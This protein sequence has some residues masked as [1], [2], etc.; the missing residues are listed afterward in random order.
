[1]KI[2]K[3]RK[4]TN[5]VAL[6]GMT[7]LLAILMLSCKEEIE[8]PPGCKINLIGDKDGIYS[9][10]DT[11]KVFASIVDFH[12][13]IDRMY[14]NINGKK[15]LVEKQMTDFEYQISPGDMNLGVN[16][17][18]FEAIDINGSKGSDQVQFELLSDKPIVRTDTVIIN[19]KTATVTGSLLSDGGLESSWGICF[20]EN[21]EPT[22]NDNKIKVTDKLFD[23]TIPKDKIEYGKKYFVRSWAENSNGISYG[24]AIEFIVFDYGLLIDARDNKEYK[25][26][27]IGGLTWMAENLAWEGDGTNVIHIVSYDDWGSSTNG[28]IYYLN[29]KETYEQFG[30]YYQFDAAKNACPSGWHLP[31]TDEWEILAQSA[32][33]RNLAGIALKSKDGWKDEGNG[34]DLLGFNILP[35]GRRDNTG[36]FSFGDSY[37]GKYSYFW[38]DEENGIYATT[39]ICSYNDNEL[40]EWTEAVKRNGMNVRCV[41]D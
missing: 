28:Y 40:Y 27:E 19:D 15:Y 23:Y 16:T 34:D 24:E 31:S 6:I 25:T 37:S 21:I 35:A 33:G 3:I 10:Y 4:Q 13:F 11:V 32:G 36:Y 26:I 29:D 20:S 5:Y 39:N 30:V 7:M 1:M 8:P 14:I 9:Y 12:A 38:A 41:K 18:G 22:I 2:S 17:V